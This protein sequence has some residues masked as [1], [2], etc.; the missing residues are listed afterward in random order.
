M[1]I[2][3]ISAIIGIAVTIGLLF[4]G[5]YYSIVIDLSLTIIAVMCLFEGL[6]A[7][8]LNKKFSI[9]IPC[10]IFTAAVCMFY[11][12]I[13]VIP[14]LF[15]ALVLSV[16]LAMIFNHENLVFPD[17]A[18]ALT[19]TA[20]CTFGFWS[21]IS[22][23]DSFKNSVGIFYIV[24]GLATPWLSDGGAYF[25]GSFLGK[26]KLCPK[27]S[28][29][30]TV[31]GA[32]TGVISGGIL[33]LIVGLIFQNFIFSGEK[34]NYIYLAIFGLLG[35]LV[36]IVGDLSFSLI[37][38]SCGIKDYGSLIPGHGGMLDR[39]DSVIFT[40]PLLMIF[41]MFLPIVKIVGDK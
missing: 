5:S 31:E 38:R 24:T 8:G 28:P 37:K 9:C 6:S 34:V 13:Y 35:A 10:V 39:F 11:S 23:Y 26:R 30:K 20:M 15:F 25:G 1:K 33:S 29:K 3:I 22:L 32:V 19:I 4:L 7:K 14:I 2:R 21:I 18:F 41:N 12:Y 40:S 27:I 36:S 16:F 17:L